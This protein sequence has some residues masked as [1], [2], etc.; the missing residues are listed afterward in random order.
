MAAVEDLCRSILISR[1]RNV[2][3]ERSFGKNY[4]VCRCCCRVKKGH[5]AIS[6]LLFYSIG[7][8]LSLVARTS[9]RRSL[10]LLSI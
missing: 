5:F 6:F 10:I 3:W 1:R 4:I 7:I 9:N 2:S 8:W